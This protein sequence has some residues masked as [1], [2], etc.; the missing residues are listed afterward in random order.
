MGSPEYR[1]VMRW[2]R[3][4]VVLA[5]AATL[6]SPAVAASSLTPHVAEYKVKIR[7]LGG[8]LNTELKVTETGYVATH[9]IRPTG[10]SRIVSR[11]TISE[12]S[13]FDTT[14]DG[15]RPRVYSSIDTISRDKNRVSVQFDWDAGEARGTV[16]GEEVVSILNDLAFDRVS[17]QYELM[18][19]F[20]S[21][22]PSRDYTMFE[23][24]RL[25]QV[26]VR[27]I[28]VRTVEVPAGKF[29]V[30]GIQH[31]AEGSKRVTTLWCAEELDYL[32]VI[33]EQHRKGKLRLRATLDKYLPEP[34]S[35]T[36]SSEQ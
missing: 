16:D 4:A 19:D 30:V 6:A 23:I 36:V 11:G 12:T 15:I 3:C 1:N 33:I 32:P 26:T 8:R 27:N 29:D 10:I 21:K 24:D 14:S 18:H 31:Q 5:C 25:R 13:E 17:I 20:L 22:G 35:R 2:W 7:V 28:G 9:V 34:D